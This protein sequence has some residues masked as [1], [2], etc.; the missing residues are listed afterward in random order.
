MTRHISPDS[1]ALLDKSKCRLRTLSIRIA[2][3]YE[4]GG[5]I[6]RTV[7]CY[8][9]VIVL[10]P[11]V[12]KGREPEMSPCATALRLRGKAVPGILVVTPF[13]PPS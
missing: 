12:P 10:S 3:V 5:I 7:P 13:S 1:S 2:A 9:N 4:K 8:A 6:C 11:R